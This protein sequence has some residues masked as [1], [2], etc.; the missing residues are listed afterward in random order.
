MSIPYI[1]MRCN[2]WT[3]PKVRKIAH[4]TGHKIAAVIGGLHWFWSQVHE[5]GEGDEVA[6]LSAN[7]VDRFTKLRGFSD[8]L[9]QVGWGAFSQNRAV[10]V[11][12][13]DNSTANAK[14][15]ERVYNATRKRNWRSKVKESGFVPDSPG[16]SPTMSPRP[17]QSIAEQSAAKQCKPN[18]DGRVAPD[19]V[20]PPSLDTPEFRAAWERWKTHRREIRHTLKPTTAASQLRTL[21]AWGVARAIAAID[22]TVFKGWQGLVEPQE[23]RQAASNG[24]TNGT[25]R[26]DWNGRLP[27]ESAMDAAKRKGVYG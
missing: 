25:V 11:R 21:E 19:G 18:P 2:L 8:A 3:N 10:A 9:V 7:D 15:R 20:I 26:E 16:D 27:G 17:K 13:S 5:H 23:T 1:E 24:T 12:F 14:E 4:L 6:G 22:H